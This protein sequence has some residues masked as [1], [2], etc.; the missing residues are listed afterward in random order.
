MFDL[1]A[2]GVPALLADYIKQDIDAYCLAKY[3]DGHRAHLGAS[4]LGHECPRYLWYTFRWVRDHKHTPR[5]Y[6]LF[7]RGHREELRFAEWLHGAGFKLISDEMPEGTQVRV[8]DTTGH[9]GGSLDNLA[10]LPDRYQIKQSIL[11]CEFK[12]NAT[13]AGFMKVREKGMRVGKPQH[14][15]QASYYGWKRGL[16]WCIYCIINKNDDD[17]EIQVV[18]LDFARAAEIE[19]RGTA[20]ILSQEPPPKISR[21]PAYITCKLC[22]HHPTCWQEKPVE[23]NCRSCKHAR[24]AQDARWLCERYGLIPQAYKDA[25]GRIIDAIKIGCANHEPIV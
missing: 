3:H 8:S 23:I 9:I 17:L 7:N 12:T 10:Q 24:P 15:D 22:D 25:D 6:R 1:D 14:F 20:I 21:T 16:E 19:Q 11:L 13:G 2:P 5:M 4:V 18:K